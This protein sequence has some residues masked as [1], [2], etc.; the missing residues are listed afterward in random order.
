VCLAAPALAQ[1]PAPPAPPPEAPPPTTIVVTHPPKKDRGEGNVA[2]KVGVLLPE[3]FS[4][5]NAS[6]LVDLEFGWVLPVLSH[7]LAVSVDA[8]FTAPELDGSTTDPRL[9]ASAGNTYSWHLQQREL[10]FGLT[11]YYRHPIGRFIPYVGIGPRLFLLQ[12]K[13]SGDASGA[14]INL[15]DEVSTKAG[16]GLPI[17]LGVTLGPGHL[18]LEYAL[19]IANIDHRTTGEVDVGSSSMTL[20]LGYRLMF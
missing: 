16:F 13:V 17:G 12:S 5:L 18:L 19:N 14:G 2:I 1:E 11:F 9:D 6:Y 3:A 20:V 4:K 7:H 8:A 15:S 10:M